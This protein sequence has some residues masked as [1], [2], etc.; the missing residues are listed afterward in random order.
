MDTL[1]SVLSADYTILES[2]GSGAFGDVVKAVHK[3]SQQIVAI[4]L[5][6]N[7]FSCDYQSKQVLSEI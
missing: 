3:E 7:L 2:I 1:W 4:K 5:M 6:K